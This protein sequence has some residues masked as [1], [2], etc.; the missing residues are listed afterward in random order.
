MV[1]LDRCTVIFVVGALLWGAGA[2]LAA[3]ALDASP[4]A[5]PASVLAVVALFAW[6]RRGRDILD[7]VAPS[8]LVSYAGYLGLAIV[9]ASQPNMVAAQWLILSLDRQWPVILLG[10]VAFALIATVFVGIPVSAIPRRRPKPVE[11]PFW[12]FVHERNAAMRR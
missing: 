2:S 11:S 12:D 9:R 3:D 8:F 6:L 4:L 5:A 10:G 1:R 7:V